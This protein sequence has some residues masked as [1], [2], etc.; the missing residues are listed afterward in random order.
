MDYKIAP[1]PRTKESTVFL[2]EERQKKE[3]VQ[4][5]IFPSFSKES[6]NFLKL[7][8]DL[9]KSRNNAS[10]TPWH[11]FAVLLRKQELTSKLKPEK[12]GYVS[13]AISRNI[14]EGAIGFNG[15]VFFSPE[16]KKVLLA[17]Y[18]VS[19]Q[20]VGRAVEPMNMFLALSVY[21]GMDEIFKSAG[22]VTEVQTEFYMP[23]TMQEYATDLTGLALTGSASYLNRKDE[24]ENVVRILARETKHN[25]V[26]LGDEGVG[27]SVLA[28]SLAAFLVNSNFSS[29]QNARVILLDIGALFSL[30]GGGQG[31]VSSITDS[32]SSM[33][34]V[35]FFLENTNLLTSGVQISQLVD[36]LQSLEK[37]GNVN[38]IMSVTPAFY[39]EFVSNNP[40]LSS[41]FEVINVDELS[42]DSTSKVLEMEASR[43][44]KHYD[45]K[46]DPTVFSE[47]SYMAKRYLPGKLPQK[48]ITLLEEVS[49]GASLNKQS[50]VT[51][52]NVRNVV[53][54]KTGIPL[55]SISESETEKLNNLES[56]IG[57]HVVGQQDA[58]V[59]VSEALRRSRAG[60][61]DAKKPIGSFLFLGPTGVGKT[62]LAKTLAKLFFNDEKSFLRFDMSEYG[63]SHTAQRLIGA[64]PGYVG[65]EEGG[66]L[67]NQVMAKPYCLILFDEIEKA[68]P[69]VFDLFLQ[70]LDDGRLTD[71]QGRVVDFRNTLII[72]TS[73]IASREIFDNGQNLS[74]PKFNR[75]EFFDKVI[76][77]QVRYFFRPEL[78]NRF[79]DIVMFNPLTKE[80]MLKIARLKVGLLKEKLKDKNIGFE[81]S[82]DKLRD[83]VEDSFDP[84]FGA[85]P[86]EREIKDK[87]ENVLAK[88]I[89]SGSIREGENITW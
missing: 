30:T 69:R 29:F 20:Q 79:D 53:A 35:I 31:E 85:R 73:N 80:E 60:L 19:K 12:F 50:K 36:F 9:A 68:H 27:K 86:L 39:K 51:I 11:L 45:V 62:E 17:S 48:A 22:F 70:I 47:V 63:E 18:F 67:T 38:L 13:D 89:I 83:L 54:Q 44:E 87:I 24:M 21:P 56:I 1:V 74:D 7:A 81:I 32:V 4:K 57:E 6:L 42:Q 75:K 52:D 16:L 14:D 41:A 72:F 10:V 15:V 82:D 71:S 43:I 61:K 49:A 8:S 55:N 5:N 37:R 76:M 26:L 78:V 77:P 59:R 64:P 33:G 58:I 34:R 65:Y 84:S 40:Y 23:K 2:R 46:I 66:Q 28:K 3:I 25:A 88:K